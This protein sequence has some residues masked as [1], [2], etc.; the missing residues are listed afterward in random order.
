MPKLLLSYRTKHRHCLRPIR[1]ML[2]RKQKR[3][4]LT[5]MSLLIAR[6][7]PIPT[8]ISQLNRRLHRPEILCFRQY[9]D[10]IYTECFRQLGDRNFIGTNCFR[11]FGDHT[12]G[13]IRRPNQPL[14]CSKSARSISGNFGCELN[15]SKHCGHYAH[16]QRYF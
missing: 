4:C 16:G 12:S 2:M 9:G 11:Q 6:E 14:R 8:M 7:F 15:C 5:N 10:N 1:A 3:K 13:C